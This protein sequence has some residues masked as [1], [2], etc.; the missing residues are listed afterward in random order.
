MR[1]KEQKGRKYGKSAYM[2]VFGNEQLGNLISKIQATVI[3][4]G[5]ELERIILSKT[6]TIDDLELFINNSEAGIQEDGI[7][8][9]SKKII[10]KSKYNVK[11]PVTDKG[12]EP[13][14]LVFI[15]E[16][17]RV[18]K[19]IELKDGDTFDTKKISGER[20]HLIM[21][22]KEFGSKIPFRTE[23]YICTFNQDDMDSIKTGLKNYFK[24]DEILTGRDFCKILNINYDEIIRLRMK[25]AE[26]NLN[27]FIDELLKIKNVRSLLERK[28]N[29]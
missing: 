10:K 8:V 21:F 29:G 28:L 18:C 14:L 22:S 2:R 13:D 12:I 4:N 27:Y 19:I 6:N 17:H 24:E 23:I 3:S 20:E 11:D 25:D 5:S 16:R 15:I 9:C 1:L 26:D 7:Y